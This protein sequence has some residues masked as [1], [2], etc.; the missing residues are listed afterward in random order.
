VGTIVAA[1]LREHGPTVDWDGDPDER[2]EVQITG[3]R[4]YSTVG[5]Y[6]ESNRSKIRYGS[7]RL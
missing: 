5:R 4:R 2:I 3:W 6:S 1:A 7:L